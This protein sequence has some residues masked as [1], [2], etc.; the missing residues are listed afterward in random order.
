MEVDAWL[1][2]LCKDEQ[3]FACVAELTVSAAFLVRDSMFWKGLCGSLAWWTLAMP[4]YLQFVTFHKSLSLKIYG[5]PKAVMKFNL[6]NRLKCIHCLMK[7]TWLSSY[8]I[9]NIALRCLISARQSQQNVESKADLLRDQWLIRNDQMTRY[10]CPNDFQQISSSFEW[11]KGHFW[12]M[13]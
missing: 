2:C 9:T 7:P 11:H 3:M 13:T 4:F 6:R 8:R 5:I 1:S 10:T 12:G